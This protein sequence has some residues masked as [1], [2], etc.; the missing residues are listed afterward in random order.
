MN[1]NCAID[2]RYAAD[3]GGAALFAPGAE[4][5][6]LMQYLPLVKRIVSQLALQANQVLDRED[7]EQ[8]GLMGLLECLR[9]YGT[10]DEQ[11]GRFA[12]L[13]V[14]GAILDELRRQDW[15]PRQVRQQTHKIRDAIRQLA[16]QL[17]RVPQEE[18]IL[19][20]IGISAKDYQEFLQADACEAIES[21]DELLQNGHE[22]FTCGS[23]AVEDRVLKERLLTQALSQLSERERLV[24][25]LYYQHELSLKE[26]ALVLELSDARVCQLSKQAIAKAS[27]YL[28]ERG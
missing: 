10:P 14:R 21:L 13:R 12:A 17:G 28:N 9:R 23:S 1:A 8:I 11:F 6:W 24:L 25:T 26:I 19:R 2:Y 16:R 18:E 27:R 3:Q 5:K 4:Q 15:R 22:G 20:A 7:M